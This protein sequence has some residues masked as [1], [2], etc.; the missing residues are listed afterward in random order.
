MYFVRIKGNG[1]IFLGQ[2]KGS[3]LLLKFLKNSKTLIFGDLH[4]ILGFMESFI[5]T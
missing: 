4:A 5:I 3:E 1:L 2:K